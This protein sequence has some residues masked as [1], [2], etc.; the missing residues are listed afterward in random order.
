MSCEKVSNIDNKFTGC[1]TINCSTTKPRRFLTYAACVVFSV[2]AL[3]LTGCSSS[4]K[5]SDTD[6]ETVLARAQSY[7][8]RGQYKATNIETKN[9]LQASPN[10]PGGILLIAKTQMEV[11]DFN[12][13][14][15]ILEN[16]KATGAT[17]SPDH[18]LVLAE[19]YINR[20]KYKTALQILNDLPTSNDKKFNAERDIL[21]GRAHNGL[22][23]LEE[24]EN[25]FQKAL[26]EN[27]DS[28][29]AYTSL[30]QYYLGH[31]KIAD[32][33][34]N[35][36]KALAINP[37]DAEV[38]AW[39][40][41]IAL[42]EKKFDDAVES[43]SA[44]LAQMP[45]TDVPTW[46]KTRLLNL[47][48]ETLTKQG[49]I[50]EAAVYQ[51]II[52]KD[53]PGR[54]D[55]E[56]KFNNAK[57]A[58]EAG[59]LDEAEKLLTELLKK[60][61]DNPHAGLLLGLVK[62]SKGDV[63]EAEKLLSKSIDPET[64]SEEAMKLLAV[65]SLK[66]N[67]PQNVLDLLEHNLDRYE[68]NPEMLSLYGIA[69]LALGNEN[70]GENAL[71]LALDLAPK[72][73]ATRIALSKYYFKKERFTEAEKLLVDGMALAPE[74]TELSLSLL[75][76]YFQQKEL[77]KVETLKQKLIAQ[78][79]NNAEV[80]NLIGKQ[81]IA[82]KDNDAAMTNFQAVLKTNEKDLTALL[83]VAA[84]HMGKLEWD[85]AEEFYKKVITI[86]S[87]E[88]VAYKGLFSSYEARN[89]QEA[90]L[91]LLNDYAQQKNTAYAA[92]AVLAEF[93]LRKQNPSTALTFAKKAFDMNNE[94]FYTRA[95]YTTS[96]YEIAKQA[97]NNKEWGNAKSA[98][99]LALQLSPN[100]AK[101]TEVLIR[102]EIGANNHDAATALINDYRKANP[103]SPLADLLLGDQLLARGKIDDALA[104]Y[105]QLWGKEK[106]PRLGGKILSV[107][108]TNKRDA[109]ALEFAN[110]WI[111]ADAA[112][113]P[114]K[115][116][117]AL[118]YQAKGDKTNA[119][120]YYEDLLDSAPND[121]VSLNNLAW[122]YFETQNAKSLSTA[123]RAFQLAPKSGAIA[124]TYGWIL[125]N[126]GQAA[127]GVEILTIAQ[128]LAPDSA[129]IKSHLDE[130]KTK[131]K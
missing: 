41:H 23:N 38:L 36:D 93:Y 2:S 99:N 103:D 121:P 111:Q 32:A 65:S 106:A 105:K 86:S 58:Y 51:Q 48:Q 39:Q 12:S 84:V 49:K 43:Y 120:K 8:E 74:D 25:W 67:H 83:G 127:K 6:I 29:N 3:T 63:T 118:D 7:Y 77:D 82:E 53:N 61:P 117:I 78:Y 24:A 62:Y 79:P 71:I 108:K 81:A 56:G 47:L 54:S 31:E 34:I 102:A 37:K 96:H 4:D 66:L 35:L 46:K 64:A 97:L 87:E 107:L 76:M 116:F 124:D 33:K 16:L 21:L 60:A 126:Q 88:I 114:P 110:Q 128:Q 100:D 92:N 131:T 57:Q 27:P 42:A 15:T 40:G 52:S 113:S 22:S 68:N 130:A 44:A 1:T 94:A 90:G 119:I 98:A 95:L 14:S 115:L 123:E 55:L 122:L 75:R 28:T 13:A 45:Q 5:Q 26:T 10:H 72:R 73:S 109:E 20:R 89:N 18:Q 59:K 91:K 129:E 69:S 70:S 125:T 9:I 19:A 50:E 30:M 17:L 11:G 85:K 101:V 112:A 80:R 104:Q